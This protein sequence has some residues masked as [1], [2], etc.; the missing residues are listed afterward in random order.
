M[1]SVATGKDMSARALLEMVWTRKLLVLIP[2]MV[3]GLAVTVYIFRQPVLYRAQAL[4]G[5]E[6]NT[7]DYVQRPEVAARVQ[8]QLLT[9]REVLLSRSVLEPVMQ[10]FRLYPS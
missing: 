9:I 7:V 8:D 10:E 3:V 6:A 2:A 5:V 4:I 1:A